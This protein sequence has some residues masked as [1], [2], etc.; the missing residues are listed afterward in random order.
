MSWPCESR[1]PTSVSWLLAGMIAPPTV[2]PLTPS[3]TLLAVPVNSVSWNEPFGVVQMNVGTVPTDAW[4]KL[5]IDQYVPASTVRLPPF[6]AFT[7]EIAS[8]LLCAQRAAVVNVTV[9]P[10]VLATINVSAALPVPT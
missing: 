1:Y 3:V 4:T 10:V 5:I 7:S 8:P 6:G 2:L 9:V